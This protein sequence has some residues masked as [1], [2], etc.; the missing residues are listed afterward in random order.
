MIFLQS[1]GNLFS[2]SHFY[3]WPFGLL[4]VFWLLVE[5]GNVGGVSDWLRNW[6]DW[7]AI[8]GQGRAGFGDMYA[9]FYSSF[10]MYFRL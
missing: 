8:H 3:L 1:N 9:R 10:I 6:F 4:L 2:N 5:N 7:L